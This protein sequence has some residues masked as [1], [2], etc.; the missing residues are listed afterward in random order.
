MISRFKTISCKLV[1]NAKRDSERKGLLCKQKVSSKRIQSTR[2]ID[3]N[4]S[5]PFK[6]SSR[7]IMA[8]FAHFDLER[9]GRY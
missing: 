5:S 6:G 3:Y 2:H 7:V 8:F 1:F 4:D 9:L